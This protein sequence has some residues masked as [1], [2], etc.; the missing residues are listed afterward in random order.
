MQMMLF[1]DKEDTSNNSEKKFEK[2]RFLETW[3]FLKTR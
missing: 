1:L 2:M 3:F